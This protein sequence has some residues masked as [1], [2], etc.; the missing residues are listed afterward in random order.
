MPNLEL[1]PRV[2]VLIIKS[3]LGLLTAAV[4]GMIMKEEIKA[5]DALEEKYFPEKKKDSEE[6][7]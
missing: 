4:I 6:T 3:S 1:R 7:S 2:K 5:V